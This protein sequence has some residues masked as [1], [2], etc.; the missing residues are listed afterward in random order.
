VT[1]QAD[2]SAS[3]LSLYRTA[4]RLR[5]REEGSG[6]PDRVAHAGAE[7]LAFRRGGDFGC[8]LN[9]ARSPRTA[10]HT[11][12]C[13]PAASWPKERYPGHAAWLRLAVHP[14]LTEVENDQ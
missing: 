1:A 4:L 14:S 7:V 2:D 13:W 3:M 8:V 10:G 9:S 12:V 11:E 6:R 5:R